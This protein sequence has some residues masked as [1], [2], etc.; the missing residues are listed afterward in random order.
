MVAQ[1]TLAELADISDDVNGVGGVGGEFVRDRW[2]QFATVQV[3]DA[4]NAYFVS[5]SMHNVWRRGKAKLG[6]ATGN[7]EGPDYVIPQ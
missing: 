3:T 7:E 2:N 1:V 6:T 5:K 4:G